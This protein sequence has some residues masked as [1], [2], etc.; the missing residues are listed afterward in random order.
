MSIQVTGFRRRL[1]NNQ[2]LYFP[3]YYNLAIDKL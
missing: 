1:L 3:L 2:R